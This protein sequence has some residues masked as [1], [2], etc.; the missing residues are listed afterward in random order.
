MCMMR[1][2][3]FAHQSAYLYKLLTKGLMNIMQHTK[4]TV[5][6]MS[7]YILLKLSN[8]LNLSDPLHCTLWWAFLFGLFLFVRKSNIVS[9]SASKFDRNKQ[10]QQKD[11]CFVWLLLVYGILSGRKR[12]KRVSANCSCLSV[13]FRDHQHVMWLRLRVWQRQ[14]RYLLTLLSVCI[15]SRMGLCLSNIP[16]LRFTCDVYLR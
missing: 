2:Y 12:F 10:L 11:T 4:R 16:P 7:H 8:V 5:L 15:L 1:K 14:L 9:P 3:C 6:S 13:V